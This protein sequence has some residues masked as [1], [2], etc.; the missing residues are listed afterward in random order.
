MGFESLGINV[1]QCMPY[2]CQRAPRL[3]YEISVRAD[4]KN[5]M[6]IRADT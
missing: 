6:P 2:T 4:T 3:L 5:E 1:V